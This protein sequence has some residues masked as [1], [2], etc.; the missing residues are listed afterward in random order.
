[1][2]RSYQARLKLTIKSAEIETYVRVN[3][4]MFNVPRLLQ[5]QI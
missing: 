3:G 1:M 4:D 2:T 5:I